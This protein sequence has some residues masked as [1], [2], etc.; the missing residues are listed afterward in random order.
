MIYEN[1][2]KDK[3]EFIDNGDTVLMRGGKF[4]RYGFDIEPDEITM[5]DPSG[6]PYLEVGQDIRGLF[7]D[8]KKRVIESIQILDLP[9]GTPAELDTPIDVLF[10]IKQ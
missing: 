10:K 4:L 6:G 5:V 8:D 9:E 7:R 3:I 2:Y 1:R